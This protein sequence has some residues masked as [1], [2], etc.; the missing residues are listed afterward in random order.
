MKKLLAVGECMLELT[1]ENADTIRK[2]YAGDTY[3]ALVY[4]NRFNP[5]I[6][7]SF[8]TAIG[9]DEVSNDMQERWAFEKISNE[10]CIKT[11]ELTIGIYSIS[12]DELGE[13]SFSYWRKN[14]AA[15]HMMTLKPLDELVQMCSGFDI[16]FFSGITLGILSDEDKGLLFDLLT[17]LRRLGSKIAFDPNYRPAMWQ[18]K[19]HAIHWLEQS[20]KNSDIVMPGLEEHEELYGHTTYQEIADYCH[21]LDAKE[22]IIKCGKNGTYGFENNQQVAHQPFE[23]APIQV[24]STAAGDS[25]AGTYLASRLSDSTIS[26]SIKN[27]CFIAGKVVQHKGAILSQT[28]YQSEIATKNKVKV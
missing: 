2:S 6:K 8:F 20:Y 11:K 25:F 12:T 28:I 19:E 15:T 4:A 22:V 10:Q 17:Q 18:N 13:R 16:V 3:N 26:Q 5:N 1:H 14:S 27:A 7:T 23:A 24:D 9:A 21:A